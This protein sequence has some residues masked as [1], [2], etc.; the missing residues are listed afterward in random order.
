MLG[1]VAYP[2]MG[3]YKSMKHRQLNPTEAAVVESLIALGNYMQQRLPA[4]TEEIEAVTA[5]LRRLV[6]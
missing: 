5:G 1:L 3:I 4:T 2:A 6:G